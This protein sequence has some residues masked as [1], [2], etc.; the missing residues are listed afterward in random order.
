MDSI[1][2]NNRSFAKFTIH[3]LYVHKMEIMVQAVKRKNRDDTLTTP[4][5]K[6]LKVSSL[7][8]SDD[9]RVGATELASA[10]AL[11]SLASFSSPMK[12]KR[13]SHI[14]DIE[15]SDPMD[16][17]STASLEARSPKED[18]VPITPEMRS[19]VRAPQNKKVTFAPNIKDPTRLGPRR[20]SFPPRI[21]QIHNSRVS[22]GFPR[23]PMPLRG[24]LPIRGPMPAPWTHRCHTSHTA[25]FAPHNDDWVC[26]YCNVAAFPTYEEACAHEE[27]CRARLASIERHHRSF[28]PVSVQAG[29]VT[30]L[31]PYLIHGA[32][33]LTA[34]L[35]PYNRLPVPSQSVDRETA[36]WGRGCASLALPESDADW[37][38]GLNCFIRKHCVEAFS[39]TTEDIN[40]PSKRGQ[41]TLHQ[42]GIRCRFCKHRSTDDKEAAAVSYPVSMAGI[43]ESV[44]RWQRVHLEVCKDVPESIRQNLDELSTENSWIPT[45][46]QYWIDSAKLLGM[47]D[48][49]GGIRFASDP[50]LLQQRQQ[51]LVMLGGETRMGQDDGTR[52]W[53]ED[54]ATD[55]DIGKSASPAGEG[56]YIVFPEDTSMVPSYVYFLIRQVESCRFTE[57]DR[58]VARSKGPVG[59][60]GFQ[61]R[62]C[63]GNAGLGKYFP[64]T[65]K[66]LATNS[67]SQNIHAH[68]LKCR[69]CPSHIKE[70]LLALK[71]EKT[72]S[73][74]LEPGWRKVFFDKIWSRLHG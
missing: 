42:V 73:P 25:S 6:R 39:A 9:E 60:P 69:K 30:R 40:T 10:F 16:E 52:D 38:S 21:S 56:E 17:S 7:S 27:Q 20:V 68:L 72:K 8:T 12:E 41:I 15:Y 18:H 26:D 47:I 35:P 28:P 58:F 45:T 33:Q 19:P 43:Y 67:T 3:S 36:K 71:D 63:H 49:A 64:V 1:S 24:H 59:Y 55:T 61:C 50:H 54:T 46:K 23:P 2:K 44:K 5:A 57:A 37:L 66:S 65:S 22:N 31:P 53:R 51:G 74:R 11:A 29:H 62:H 13:P 70:Q 48:T 4:D 14:T 34:R 32:T